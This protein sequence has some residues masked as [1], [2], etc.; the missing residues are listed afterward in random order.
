MANVPNAIKCNK[1][2]NLI[3]I[4]C[5]IVRKCNLGQV[6]CPS[7]LT[8]N[9]LEVNRTRSPFSSWGVVLSPLS[10]TGTL[11]SARFRAPPSGPE[12]S[13]SLAGLIC[14]KAS[15]V[16]E[17]SRVPILLNWVMEKLGRYKM[18]P[19]FPNMRLVIATKYSDVTI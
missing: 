19:C 7:T 16:G 3:S 10:G 11:C 18:S 17:K 1:K 15:L 14:E 5:Q 13:H 9:T 2:W 6:C 12:R 8:H 4:S